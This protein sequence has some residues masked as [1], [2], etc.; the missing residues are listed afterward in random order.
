MRN[1]QSRRLFHDGNP[2]EQ[3]NPKAQSKWMMARVRVPPPKGDPEKQ[4]NISYIE[5]QFYIDNTVFV[6]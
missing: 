2:K 3:A 5:A 4:E 1:E 6:R